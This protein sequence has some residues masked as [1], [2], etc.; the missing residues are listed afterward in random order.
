MA[1]ILFVNM[2][3]TGLCCG[4]EHAFSTYS[5]FWMHDRM[6]HKQT[7]SYSN[8]RPYALL[9]PNFDQIFYHNVGSYAPWLDLDA[10]KE[11]H[12]WDFET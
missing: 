11:N 5:S 1:Q 7:P 2:A 8:E 3:S 6:F 12:D 9:I 10:R 4:C